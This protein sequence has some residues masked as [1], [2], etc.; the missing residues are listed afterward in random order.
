MRKKIEINETFDL[1]EKYHK[2]N[3]FSE[4]K[5]L[6]EKIIKIEPNHLKTIFRLGS[7]LAQT[8]NFDKV[9]ILNFLNHPSNIEKCY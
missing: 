7:L 8:N 9:L 5:K 4:A 1:A 3:N 2:K 6:Y